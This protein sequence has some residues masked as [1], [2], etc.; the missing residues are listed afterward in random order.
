MA[1][2]VRTFFTYSSEGSQSEAVLVDITREHQMEDPTATP[3]WERVAVPILLWLD[4]HSLGPVFSAVGL[5]ADLDSDLDPQEVYTELEC[6]KEMEFITYEHYKP[7][8]TFPTPTEWQLQKV[9]MLERAST[10]LERRK[11]EP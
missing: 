1:P 5:A 3:T 9:K 4:T 8:G 11:L 6:L 10:Y 2:R 7:S